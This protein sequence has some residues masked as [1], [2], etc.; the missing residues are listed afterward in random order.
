MV[1][2]KF[3]LT[4]WLETLLQQNLLKVSSRIFPEAHKKYSQEQNSTQ[5]FLNNFFLLPL[6]RTL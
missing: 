4:N 1:E 6:K 3:V 2:K 5:Q